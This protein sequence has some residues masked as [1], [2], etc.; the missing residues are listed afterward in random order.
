M[1]LQKTPTN[2]FA[3]GGIEEIGK[4]MYVIEHDDEIFIIDCGI[5]FAD[6]NELLGVNCVIPSFDYLVENK[7][8]IAGLII[9]HGH[10]DHI[11]GIPYLLKSIPIKKIY[12]SSLTAAL[13]KRKFKD[14]HDILP[15][16]IQVIDDNYIIESKYFKIEFFRV[17]HSIPLS[18]G[19]S[20]TTP[21]GTIVTAGDFRFDFSTKCEQTDIHKI[22][23]ISKR[24]VDILLCETTNAESPGFSLSEKYILDEIRRHIIKAHGR[25]FVTTFASNLG[26][27]ENIIEIAIQAKRKICIIGKAMD[28]NITTSINIGCLKVLKS[29]FI[30]ADR[31]ANY[32]DNEILV[33]LTGSQGEPTAAL[34]MMANGKHQSINLKP[35]DTILMSSNPIPGNFLS[36][37]NLVNKLYKLNLTIIQNS[38]TTRLHASGH[39]TQVEQ[40][41]MVRL[42]NPK[43]ILPIHGEYKMLSAMETTSEFLG[44]PKE[45]YLQVVNGQKVELLNH[46]AKATDVFVEADEVYVDGNKINADSSKL[47][48]ARRIL[49]QDGIFN[50]TLLINRQK[51][52]I[53]TQPTLITRGCF[54]SNASLPLICKLSYAIKENIE[55]EMKKLSAPINNFNIRKIT[56]NTIDYYIW[57]NK[58]KKPL[59]RVTVFDE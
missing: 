44:F 37:E 12:A 21:N 27:I 7:D 32:T 2:V 38:P 55:A 48:S 54:Y 36:V 13:F 3:L 30:E 6:E 28:T 22:C 15:H 52:M 31:L 53:V 5:K 19:V 34:N 56:E 26:R 40:Q 24:G 47:L 51:R 43:Y 29:D 4:N 10:E 8:K 42:V 46:V 41:L 14:H 58:H 18:Y 33:L 35:S 1:N 11:G 59:V 45:N 57:K 49:S 25:V 23:D 39:A 9:T 16:E 20:L 50:V 17:C